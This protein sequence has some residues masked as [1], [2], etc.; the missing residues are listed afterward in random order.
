MSN[1]YVTLKGYILI[2]RLLHEVRGNTNQLYTNIMNKEQKAALKQANLNNADL[3]KK[4]LDQKADIQE[5]AKEL[6]D[7]KVFNEGQTSGKAHKPSTNVTEK[8]LDLAKE[9]R[10]AVKADVKR[11]INTFEHKMSVL[12]QVCETANGKRYLAQ[13]NLK[14][15]DIT[16]KQVLKTLTSLVVN[17]KNLH[18]RI[19]PLKDD[20]SNMLTAD[21]LGAHLATLNESGILTNAVIETVE[22]KFSVLDRNFIFE[23]TDKNGLILS[24]GKKIYTFAIVETLNYNVIIDRLASYRKI[25]NV[26]ATKIII[27]R[28]NEKLRAEKA[29]KLAKEKAD[30]AELVKAKLLGTL[31]KEEILELTKQYAA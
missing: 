18:V 16:K 4:E 3:E 6:K 30:K 27:E 28:K 24:K 12:L 13:N 14:I 23:Q 21:L 26:Q 10:T 11:V 29:E 25:A 22:I 9:S 15:T 31:T 1:R 2:N 5:T 7:Q 8:P 19:V 17:G 20:K